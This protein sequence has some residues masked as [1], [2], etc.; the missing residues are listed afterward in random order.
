M[1][2]ILYSSKAGNE[3]RKYQY[4]IIYKKKKNNSL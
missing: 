4:T 2:P 1:L 3:P